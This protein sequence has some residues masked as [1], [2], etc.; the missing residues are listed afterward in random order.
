M[1]VEYIKCK[2]SDD[3]LSP[4]WRGQGHVARFLNCAPIISLELV[5]PGNSNFV[6]LMMRSSTSSYVIYYP[7]E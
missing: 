7:P 3:R 2:F 5:K 6:C 4:N 1:Q